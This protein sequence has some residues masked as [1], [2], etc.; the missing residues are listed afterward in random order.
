[1]FD[2]KK[3]MEKYRED[4]KEEI[5]KQKEEYEKEHSEEIRLKDKIRYQVRKNNP[6]LKMRRKERDKVKIKARPSTHECILR[7]KKEIEESRTPIGAIILEYRIKLLTMKFNAKMVDRYSKPLKEF[8]VDIGKPPENILEED[9][10]KYCEGRPKKIKKRNSLRLFY[11]VVLNKPL[12]GL[13]SRYA[14]F[15][16]P[17]VINRDKVLERL[18]VKTQPQNKFEE[19]ECY[20]SSLEGNG[21]K[22]SKSKFYCPKSKTQLYVCGLTR[23][24]LYE[25]CVPEVK[26][27]KIP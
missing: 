11:A 24:N 12:N 9:I 3:Y 26:F 8:L 19:D 18:S 10:I 27:D 5:K 22:K 14:A 20:V 21:S 25:K 7:V 17:V 23:C 15:K 13:K 1:M 6:Q 16:R 4:H 2:K